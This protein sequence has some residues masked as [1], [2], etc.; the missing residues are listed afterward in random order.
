MKVLKYSGVKKPLDLPKFRGNVHGKK[1][2]FMHYMLANFSKPNLQ[3]YHLPT[4][5]IERWYAEVVFRMI[6]PGLD[7]IMKQGL[8]DI[9][10]AGTKRGNY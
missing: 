6:A 1:E 9:Q 2:G 8:S 4:S 10:M 3:F 5:E 7:H